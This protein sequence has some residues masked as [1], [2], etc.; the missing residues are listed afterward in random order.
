[1][2]GK[3]WDKELV[4]CGELCLFRGHDTDED[5]R[6]IKGVLIGMQIRHYQSFLVAQME[7]SEGQVDKK[8]KAYTRKESTDTQA[9]EP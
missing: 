6:D 3:N 5:L 9:Y 2:R 8:R 4:L 1:M 7:V